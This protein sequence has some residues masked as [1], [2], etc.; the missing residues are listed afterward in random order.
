MVLGSWQLAVSC[1][2]HFQKSSLV[3]QGPIF[4]SQE[5]EAAF[6]SALQGALSCV[7]KAQL[8]SA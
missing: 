6:H 7:S 4:F 1:Q 3:L 5:R 2:W 8:V